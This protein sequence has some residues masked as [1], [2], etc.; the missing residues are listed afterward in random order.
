M[1]ENKISVFNG[2]VLSLIDNSNTSSAWGNPFES[3]DVVVQVGTP[4]PPKNWHLLPKIVPLEF[5]KVK[6]SQANLPSV[7]LYGATGV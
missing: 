6:Y 3:G 7:N 1:K 2:K 5:L 4:I